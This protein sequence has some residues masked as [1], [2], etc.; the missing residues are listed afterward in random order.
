MEKSEIHLQL[1]WVSNIFVVLILAMLC[2][3]ISC[4]AIFITQSARKTKMKVRLNMKHQ[5]PHVIK[6]PMT[7]RAL[8]LA[9]IQL[10]AESL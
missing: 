3:G 9:T 4:W 1:E 5:F 6:V 8:E 2:Q 7:P 10:D